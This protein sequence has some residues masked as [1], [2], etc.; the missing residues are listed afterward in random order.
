MDWFFSNT[1]QSHKKRIVIIP[2]TVTNADTMREADGVKLV[3]GKES[4]NLEDCETI[5]ISKREW[6]DLKRKINNAL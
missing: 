3:I 2:E 6:S 5:S 1:T 4:D